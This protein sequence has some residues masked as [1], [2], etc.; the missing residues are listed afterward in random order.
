MKKTL[1]TTVIVFVSAVLFI[2]CTPK[3]PVEKL[4][5]L[6]DEVEL[7]HE[8]Y[9][10]QDW[11]KVALEYAEIEAK[12]KEEARSKEELKEFGRQKGRISG[13]MTKHT[14]ENWGEG[15]EEFANELEGSIDGFFESIGNM[16]GE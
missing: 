14:L 11:E 5:T 6:A 10:E 7:N 1:L 13:Y 8:S 9:S 2:C 15:I 4:R 12:F 3:S 16:I